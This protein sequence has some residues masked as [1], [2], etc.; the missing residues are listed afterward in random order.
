MAASDLTIEQGKTFRK[1]LRWETGPIIYKPITGVTQ[2]APARLTVPSHGLVNGWR[3]AV[4]SVKGMTQINAQ[5]VPPKST[6][7]HKVTVIDPNT[8]ELNDV[9]AAEYKAYQSGGYLQ[10]NTPVNMTDMTARMSIKDKIGGILL[11][12][13]TTENDRIELDN[14]AK[15]ITLV[16][17]ASTT[18]ALSWKKGVY[19][20]EFVSFDGTVTKMM[21]GAVSVVQEVTT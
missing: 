16:I 20:I 5:N 21:S 11:L 19:D 14:V 9:N 10:F 8:V 18:A 17:S 1:V 15:T 12:S 4:V 3:V 6:D 13:L 2:A 7:Y